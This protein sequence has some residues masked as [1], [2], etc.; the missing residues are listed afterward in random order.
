LNDISRRDFIGCAAAGCAIALTGCGGGT[1][2][3][4]VTPSNGVAQLT[5]TQYP[6]LMTVGGGVVVSTPN[7]TIVVVRTGDTTV[8]ALSAICT[9]AGCVVDYQGAGQNPA[10]YCGCHGSSFSITGSVESGPARGPLRS[11]AAT[12]DAT[13]VNVTVG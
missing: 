2:N 6:A 5:F 13:G 12:V 11:Y 9:H 10:F 4:N 8:T 7:A 1:V 3:G